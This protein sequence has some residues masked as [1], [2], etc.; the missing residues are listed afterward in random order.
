ML[1]ACMLAVRSSPKRLS[2][3]PD[4]VLCCAAAP[5]GCV[6]VPCCAL[7]ASHPARTAATEAR[8][9]V[10]SA[11]AALLSQSSQRANSSHAGHDRAIAQQT[12]EKRRPHAATASVTHSAAA[13]ATSSPGTV[14]QKC[15]ALSQRAEQQSSH[16]GVRTRTTTRRQGTAQQHPSKHADRSRTLTHGAV[17]RPPR[18]ANRQSAACSASRQPP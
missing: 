11:S 1:D 14:A 13:P 15:T 8:T 10:P 9:T 17:V 7:A 5:L 12:G 3:G 18:R 4:L 2:S 6:L 16:T